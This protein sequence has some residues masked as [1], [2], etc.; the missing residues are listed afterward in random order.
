MQVGARAHTTSL[1]AFGPPLPSASQPQP[2]AP[3]PRPG[4]RRFRVLKPVERPPIALRPSIGPVIPSPAS[5]PGAKNITPSARQAAHR[6]EH[7]RLK[8]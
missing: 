5:G 3:L 4:L 2:Y 1:A 6:L 8:A 7:H